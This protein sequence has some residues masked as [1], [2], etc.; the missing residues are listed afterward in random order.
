MLITDVT[1][2]PVILVNRISSADVMQQMQTKKSEDLAG[3]LV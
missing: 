3:G 2:T 1:Y